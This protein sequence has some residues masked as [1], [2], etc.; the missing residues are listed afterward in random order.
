[1]H[2]EH[3]LDHQEGKRK[4][5]VLDQPQIQAYQVQSYKEEG[6]LEAVSEVIEVSDLPEEVPGLQLEDLL[7]IILLD[8]LLLFLTIPLEEVVKVN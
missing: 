2:L 8:Q 7:A 5:K 3:Q 1:M 4:E 6:V